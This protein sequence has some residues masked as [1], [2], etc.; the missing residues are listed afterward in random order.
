[1][2]KDND[3]DNDVAGSAA[4]HRQATSRIRPHRCAK[5][6]EDLLLALANFEVQDQLQLVWK[7]MRS[8]KGQEPP[9]HSPPSTKPDRG[10]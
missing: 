3:N 8:E 7:C 9:R 10:V 4:P 1:M 2:N 6:V 5:H